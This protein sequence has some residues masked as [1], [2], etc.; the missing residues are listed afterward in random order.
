MSRKHKVDYLKKV[1][2]IVF[3]VS[4][5]CFGLYNYYFRGGKL[6]R[7]NKYTIGVVYGSHWSLKAGQFIDATYVINDISYTI[8]ESAGKLTNQSIIGK[9]FLVKFYPAEP[10][11]AV[12]YINVPVPD[13][14]K[15]PANGWVI[16][17]FSV[18]A[19]I[20]EQTKE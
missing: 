8:S 19:S 5:I 16:P 9:R 11:V 14:V 7:D 2:G 4:F 6:R 12:I 13:E 15:V 18:P 3:F 1:I 17:P 20:T 10:E